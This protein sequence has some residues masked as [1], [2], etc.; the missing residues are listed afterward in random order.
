MIQRKSMTSFELDDMGFGFDPAVPVFENITFVMPTAK[1]V[2]VR[3]PGGRG[4]S[5]LLKILAGLIG[6]TS[7]HYLINGLR[8]GDMSFEDFLGYRLNMGYG[9][10]M[11]GLLNNKTTTENLLLPLQYHNLVTDEEA[12]NRVDQVIDLFGLQTIAGSRPFAISGSQRKLTCVVRA[13]IHWPQIVFLDDP[14]TGLKQD[15]LNDLYHYVEESFAVR[16][17]KQIFFT[18][19]NPEFAKKFAAEELL[20][21]CDWFT[22]RSVA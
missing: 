1:A 14:M 6:P 8:V 22:A 21:S 2:W 9:F 3:S 15:N 7:G 20:I 17:L 5:T 12:H 16:G 18:S 10:D 11:G 13:F 19:E 4:K